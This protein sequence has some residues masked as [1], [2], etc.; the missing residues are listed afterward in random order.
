M[1]SPNAKQTSDWASQ[2]IAGD[3][4]GRGQPRSVLGTP[5]CDAEN[6]PLIAAA[7]S[8]ESRSKRE[9][10]CFPMMAAFRNALTAAGI[11]QL[12]SPQIVGEAPAPRI[13]G[14]VDQPTTA[15]RSGHHSIIR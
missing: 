12:V 15:Q 13:T 7:R 11:D 1:V 9:G 3:G 2:E 5:L 14:L 6:G 4:S 10:E 8:S